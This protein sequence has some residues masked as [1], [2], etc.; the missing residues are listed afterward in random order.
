MRRV[1]L[2]LALLVGGASFAQAEEASPLR[3]AL[4]RDAGTAP[5]LIAAERHD[6][7][8][9]GIAPRLI[10]LPSD[11]AVTA[12]VADGRAEIGLAATSAPFFA[13]AAGHGLKIIASRDSDQ[14]SFPIAVLLIGAK[15]RSA[16]HTGLNVLAGGRIGIPAAQSG[17]TYAVF[18]A[19]ERFRIA[20]QSVQ[21]LSFGTNGQ[22][23]A[24]LRRGAVDAV[25]LPYADAAQAAGKQE[26]I[27]RLSD[28]AQWQQGVVF[29]A[30]GTLAARHDAVQRFMRG[31]QR[32]TAEYQ[33]NFLHY[34]DGG[35]FIE[36]PRTQEDLALLAHRLGLAPGLLAAT[37]RYCDR[38]GNPDAA[39]LGQQINFWQ[40]RGR[41]DKGIKPADLLDLSF[42]GEEMAAPARPA[43]KG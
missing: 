18:E 11:A 9:E 26:R 29:A 40:E 25:L 7:E 12:A 19:A 22:A 33:L 16:G 8:A 13:A 37:K 5:L 23:L 28:Y 17:A 31:Y 1:L 35:D 21:T 38:R 39:D 42:I 43:D 6:F 10:L 32:G 27:L 36:G 30:A 20:A 4:T 3:I 15:A 14:T 2:L 41:L 34:D 24:A